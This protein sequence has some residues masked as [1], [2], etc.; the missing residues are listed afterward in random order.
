MSESQ[1]PRPASRS[2]VDSVPSIVSLGAKYS[3]L[4]LA[5][6]TASGLPQA[7][8]LFFAAAVDGSL[9]FVSGA[10]SR[11]SLN[12]AATGTAA[13]T[14]YGDT[15]SWNEIAGAQMEG[16]V[17]AIPAGPERDAAW[18]TYK[19][20][21]PFVA[22]FADEVSRSNFYRFTPRWVRLIDNSVRFGY[23]EEFTVD[24]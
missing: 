23:R 19:A 9:I 13:V 2:L 3:T 12:I 10:E 24:E 20:K 4:T 1:S 18:D 16:S 14:M 8:P 6:T 11:H 21:F 15:W 5:T 17:S 7:A 22:E